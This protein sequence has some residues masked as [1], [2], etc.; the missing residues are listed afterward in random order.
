MKASELRIGNWVKL[1]KE[2]T[3]LA[4]VPYRYNTVKVTYI[5][6]GFA[7]KM[8]SY[9]EG[10]DYLILWERFNPFEED[11]GYTLSGCGIPYIEPIPLTE[12]WLLK[13][14]YNCSNDVFEKNNKN[15]FLGNEEYWI[16]EHTEVND[17]VF[18]G[19]DNSISVSIKHVHQ[20]Q[21]LYFALTGE[22]LILK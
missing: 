15:Y 7:E 19:Y 17:F 13:F 16:Q 2:F 9:I 1:T 3:D 14:G 6:D 12:E 18:F 22:E 20:L 5:K 4:S 10:L 11:T 21:N 8:E